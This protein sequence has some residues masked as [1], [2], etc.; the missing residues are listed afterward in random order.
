MI[1]G[2]YFSSNRGFEMLFEMLKS[3]RPTRL[4]EA[5]SGVRLNLTLSASWRLLHPAS[6]M[7]L[8]KSSNVKR[9]ISD[10]RVVKLALIGH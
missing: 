2:F 6:V 3:A 10:A 1:F 4:T 5:S 9:H 8:S 7:F